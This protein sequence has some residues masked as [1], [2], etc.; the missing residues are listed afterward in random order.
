[1]NQRLATAII[2]K[3]SGK[4]TRESDEIIRCLAALGNPACNVINAINGTTIGTT[5]AADIIAAMI[6]A[7]KVGEEE[8]LSNAYDFFA[9][10]WFYYSGMKRSFSPYDGIM[11]FLAMLGH[12]FETGESNFPV[13]QALARQLYYACEIYCK[14]FY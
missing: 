13:N 8:D 3:V 10:V 11:E 9:D 7:E 12:A 6:N 5:T 2:Y 1:M 4:F 14:Y